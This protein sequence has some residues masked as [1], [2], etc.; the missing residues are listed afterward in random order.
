MKI[1]K[2]FTEL[3]IVILCLVALGLQIAKMLNIGMAVL[4]FVFILEVSKKQPE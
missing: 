2:G 1:F 4:W 3:I